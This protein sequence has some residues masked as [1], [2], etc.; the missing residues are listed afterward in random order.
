MSKLVWPAPERNKAAI[1]EVL[2][3][4]LPP[5]GTLLEIA[6]GTG[7][8]AAHFAAAL[9]AIELLP[10]DVDPHNLASIA[11][12]VEEAALANLRAP[13]A[14][15]VLAPDWGVAS[16]D[17]IFNANLIH[18][19]PWSCAEGLLRGAAR[20][21]VRGGVLVVYGPFR[22]NG[23]H[24]AASNE[25]FDAD[26]RSRDVRFGVRDAEAVIEFAERAGLAF[27]ERVAMPANNQILVFRRN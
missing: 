25:A 4:V 10:S 13:L 16:V 24:T 21:L 14:L 11:A 26:L 1:L 9:P 23:A 17:A 8:H 2:Q 22:L 3:R 19:T 15:D 12:F 18:I 6:S 7:Q 27:E 20:H 5:R